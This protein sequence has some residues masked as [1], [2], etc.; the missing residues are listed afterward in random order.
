MEVGFIMTRDDRLA[1]SGASF[2]HLI[3]TN[4][5]TEDGKSVFAR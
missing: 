5:G 1:Q 3:Q 2:D 4:Y